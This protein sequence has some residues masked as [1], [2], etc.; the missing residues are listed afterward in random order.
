ML[1]KKNL[2]VTLMIEQHCSA[3]FSPCKWWLPPQF[4]ALGKIIIQTSPCYALNYNEF[5]QCESKRN[6]CNENLIGKIL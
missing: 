6:K 3:F 5:S 4:Y 2:Q 1:K